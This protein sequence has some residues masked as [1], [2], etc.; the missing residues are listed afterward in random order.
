MAWI[1]IQTYGHGCPGCGGRFLRQKWKKVKH[2]MMICCPEQFDRMSIGDLCNMVCKL[3]HPGC[4]V[5]GHS[6]EIYEEW[7]ILQEDFEI[8]EEWR[9]LQEEENR[10]REEAEAL[11]P[12]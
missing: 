9:I 8:C 12:K 2:H 4:E 3:G 5:P 10:L 11:R 7:R 1:A 6:F